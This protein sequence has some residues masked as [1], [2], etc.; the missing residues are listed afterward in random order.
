M[1]IKIEKYVKIEF[2]K[3][4]FE[5]K[6]QKIK[7]AILHEKLKWILCDEK[8]IWNARFIS[9]CHVTKHIEKKWLKIKTSIKKSKNE[10]VFQ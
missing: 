9:K 7:K 1:H 4:T 6:M 10:F 8:K 2:A 5:K 3:N